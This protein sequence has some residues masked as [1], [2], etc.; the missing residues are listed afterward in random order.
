[1]ANDL[2]EDGYMDLALTI[3][4]LSNN[5]VSTQVYIMNPNSHSFD[6]RYTLDNSP[7]NLFVLDLGDNRGINLLFYKDGKRIFVSFDQ[8][9]TPTENDFSTLI[10]SNLNL[11]DASAK[12]NQFEILS[13]NSNGYVDIDGD[14]LNDIL[15]MSIDKSTNKRYLEIWKGII[16]NDKIRYC[17]TSSNVYELDNSLGLFTIVDID[18]NAMPDLV[19]PVLNSSPPKIVI[20]YNKVPIEYDWTDNYC[21]NHEPIKLTSNSNAN[22]PTMFDQIKIDL[23]NNYVSTI[24]L[25]NDNQLTFYNGENGALNYYPTYLHFI[26]IKQDSYP[27]FST[28]LYNKSSQSKTPYIFYSQEILYNSGFS[29]FERRAFSKEHMET[30]SFI[31]NAVTSS[32]FDF[33]DKGKM[34]LIVLDSA[35]NSIGLYNHNIYDTYSMKSFLL[36]KTNCFYCNEL[37]S[38]Q[39]FITT[40]ID[41]TRRMDLSIQA[42]QPSIIGGLTQPFAY[43]GIGRSNNYI[44]NFHIIS[45]TEEIRSDNDKVYTPVIPNSQLVIFHDSKEG[46]TETTWKVDLIVKPTKNLKLL[47][48]VIVLM[49]IIMTAVAAYLQ[50]KEREEDSLENK[51]TFAPWFG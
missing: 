13:P 22:I 40:N 14:C 24:T 51:E 44:E 3:Q 12:H 32:F 35:M 25:I 30:F 7:Q 16:E 19:F 43:I 15:I 42:A 26:D 47:I 10:P 36:F 33:G 49:I 28:V 18:R 41:G 39:R 48:F 9:G 8:N 31:S 4:D 11:C 38:T 37:G 6:L 29:G 50:M 23:N 17:L 46:S 21:D 45:G 27:D 20:A 2:N 34:G 5:K 1:M